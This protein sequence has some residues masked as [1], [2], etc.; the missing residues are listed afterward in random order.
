MGFHSIKA[1]I[2]NHQKPHSALIA[3]L[4][5]SKSVTVAS[6]IVDVLGGKTSAMTP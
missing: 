5:Q 4:L 1:T 2:D 6:Q 3:P